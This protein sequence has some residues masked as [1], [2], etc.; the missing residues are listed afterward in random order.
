MSLIAILISLALERSFSDLRAYRRFEWFDKYTDKIKTWT[1]ARNWQGP[2]VVL[3]I[4]LGPLFAVIIINVLLDNLVLGLLSLV[5]TTVVL[6]LCLGPQDI[7]K[8]IKTFLTAWDSEDEEAAKAAAEEILGEAPPEKSS[9]LQQRLVERVLIVGSEQIL[10]PII[11]F[12]VFVLLGS[13]P[14]GVVLYRLSCQLKQRFGQESDPFAQAVNRLH[15]ILGWVPAHLVAILFAMAG[16]FVDAIHYWQQRRS[17]WQKDWQKT[18]S[19]AVLTVGL[20]SLKMSTEIPEE[21][22]SR[23]DVSQHVRAVTGLM[24]RSVVILVVIVAVVTLMTFGR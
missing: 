18:A 9:E 3:L 16:S 6:F 14:L 17:E 1:D 15:A 11:W 5:F 22:M 8:Q 10:S 20:G 13:G 4:I 21:E 24:L 12:T 23:E 2:I 19:L 7:E